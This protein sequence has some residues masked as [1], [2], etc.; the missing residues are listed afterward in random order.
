MGSETHLDIRENIPLAPLTTLRVGGPARFFVQVR[1]EDEVSRAL[2]EASSRGL[3]VFIL[4]GG[5]NI[6]VSDDGFDGL[7]IRL[8]L[9]G[10]RKLRTTDPA[11]NGRVLIR[12]QAGVDW[13]TFVDYCV[14][15]GLAGV[16]CLSGIPGMVGGTPIQNVGAYGQDVSETIV[17]VR[18]FD[19]ER[20]EIEELSNEDCGFSYR[21]SIFNSTARDRYIVLA[22]TFALR[23]NGSPTISYGDL[24][25]VFPDREPSLAE[26]RTAVLKIRRAKSMVIDPADP[27][28]RSAGSFFKNPI[29]GRSQLTKIANAVSTGDVPYFEAGAG[30]VKVPAA[31]LIE[32]AGFR[33]GYRLGNAGI[34]AN[35]S[36]ALINRDGASS[37]EILALM[38]KIVSS[39]ADKFGVELLPEP[40][41]VGFGDRRG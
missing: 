28:S 6:L 17:K 36:L 31:W 7:V 12:A 20:G 39:V 25:A 33:K 41:F 4:G 21:R 19:R 3:E 5:S 1:N 8:A 18:C 23:P 10:V 37:V 9:E 13:D 35:H 16:E 38:E 29:I 15:R 40:I 32:K 26:T 22:V 14:A 11:L 2:G 30:L 24:K 34:S 27:N